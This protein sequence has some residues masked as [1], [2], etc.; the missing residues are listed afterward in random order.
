MVVN[1]LCW[2][3]GSTTRASPRRRAEA[4]N[5]DCAAAAEAYSCAVSQTIDA[6]VQPAVTDDRVYT[7]SR[8]SEVVAAIFTNPYQRVWGASGEPPLPVYEV[9]YTK[10]MGGLA[11]IGFP[12]QFQRDSARIL[13]SRADLRWGADGKGF[14]RLVH[15]NGVCLI[16]RWSIDEA[17]TYSGYFAGG[18]TALV[19]ARYSTCCTET[20]RGRTRSLSMVGKLF[21]T[22]DPNHLEPLPTAHFVTQEDIGGADTEFINDAELRN[23]PDTTVSRRGAGVPLLTMVAVV[24]RRVDSQPT[25]RQLYQI[26]ELGKPADQPTRAPEFMR[27]LVDPG[28]PKIPDAN[29]DFRDEIMAQIFDKGDPTPRRTLRFTIEVTDEGETTGPA[30]RERRT[31]R[32]WRRIG[33]LVFDNAVI[34]YNGDAVIHFSHPTW[35]MDRNDPATATRINGRKVR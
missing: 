11:S 8:F 1:H 30:T 20:R 33:S 12:G 4:C 24:F 2:E 28:Q 19:V 15:P 3:N 9:T 7:G 29:L 27:L 35:R 13:D 6:S 16:G 21:P 10:V 32:N 34:S 31:F 23:A 5:T 18:S 26:A 14:R 17:T 22:T 25:I